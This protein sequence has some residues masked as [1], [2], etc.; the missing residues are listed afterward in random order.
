[1]DE[2]D[3][4]PPDRPAPAAADSLPGRIATLT[5]VLA[6]EEHLHRG[7]A[8]QLALF[9]HADASRALAQLALFSNDEEARSAAIE[10]LRVRR[11]RDYTEVLMRG[12]AYPWPAVARRAGEALVKLDRTDLVPRLVE[13]LEQ[14]DP[15]LPVVQEVA[16]K[17]VPVV[18]ELVRLNHHRNCLL[19]HAPLLD[20]RHVDRDGLE[21]VGAIPIPG[22]VFSVLHYT[23]DASLR[24]KVRADMTYLRHDF[25]LYQ[26]VRNAD[27]WPAMQRFDFVVRTRTFTEEEAQ[28]YRDRLQP[29]EPGVLS[30]YHRVALAALREL[31]GKDTAPTAQAWRKLLG[32]AR[33]T[34]ADLGGFQK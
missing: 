18:R 25:S 22:Q 5:Y 6:P 17:R 2:E 28:A 34:P 4:P 23:P 30:P 16:G 24:V 10:A 31:T 26:R 32:Q 15:R 14:P 12:F 20:S 29:R 13:V 1:M 9:S 27:P 19:C 3:A 7:L 8:A 21:M 33:Q 11:E